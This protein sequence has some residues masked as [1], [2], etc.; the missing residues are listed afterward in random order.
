[1]RLPKSNLNRG[2]FLYILG[3]NLLLLCFA[4]LVSG[5]V[6]CI[7]EEKESLFFFSASFAMLLLGLF[8]TYKN[9]NFTCRISKK[10]GRL[11]VGLMWLVV[12]FLGALPYMFILT[13]FSFVN[14]LFES[15]S[16]YTTTGASIIADMAT[17]PKG[18]LFYRSLTQWIGG[19]GFAMLVIIFVRNFPDGSKNLFN[20]EFN[21]IEKEKERPHI[22]STVYRIFGIYTG[23]TILCCTLLSLGDMN[24]FEALCHTFSTIS[25]GGFS[26]ADGNIGSYSDYSQVVVMVF[27]F[28]SGI[29]YFLLIWFVRGRWG[30]VFRDEQLRMYSLMT[31]VFGIGF[32][33]YFL[34]KSNMNFLQS[35][36][37]SFF[38]VVS[39]L[40]STGFDLKAPG[41]GIFVSAGLVLL[42]F[43][44]G[45]SASSSTG[46]K[47]I[48]SIILLKYIPVA[49]KRVFHP[50][51]IIPVRY[52]NK[53]LQDS[54]VNLVFGFF[55]LFFVIFLFGLIGLTMTGNSFMHAFALSAASISNIGPVMGSLAEGFSYNELSS[56]SKYI[57]IILML[58]GRLEIYAFFAILSPSVWSKR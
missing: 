1:M 10:D 47:I 13:K 12:P 57:I 56:L 54:A 46:L 4:F 53:A 26:V 2:I 35:I 20:A 33:L 11:I 39:T 9:K 28:L 15:Y 14:S 42:M 34:S 3:N 50:R 45:C 52:N 49:M 43:I 38:Y 16:G 36:K 5:V 44:G 25:T 27:M 51:A 31:L 32:S 40:S 19:L 48:R 24:F 29:S 6:S 22:K 55:F 17:V 41:L 8:T 30:K 18:L 23:F 21:S 7:Y 58:I 37:T